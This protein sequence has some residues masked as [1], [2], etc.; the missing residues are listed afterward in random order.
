MATHSHTRRP[1]KVGFIKPVGQ[2]HVNVEHNGAMVRVDKDVQLMK[3]CVKMPPHAQPHTHLVL[4]EGSCWA[5]CTHART[6]SRIG[7][8]DWTISTTRT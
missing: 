4:R 7:T 8:L 2:Q 3:E 6:D 5:R 1:C